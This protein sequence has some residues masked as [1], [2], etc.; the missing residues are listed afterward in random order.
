[1][2]PQGTKGLSRIKS[3]IRELIAWADRE[4]CM[5]PDEFAYRRGWTVNRAGFGCRVYRD[6]R[7]DQLTRPAKVAEEVS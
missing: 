4:I 5:E 6:P 1:M 7:F 2:Y 3:R